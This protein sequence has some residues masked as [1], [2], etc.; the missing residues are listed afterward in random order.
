MRILDAHGTAA[1]LPY[2]KLVPAIALAASQKMSGQI[3]APERQVVNLDGARVLL[4]MPAVAH[5]IGINKFL[6]V[7]AENSRIGLPS[8]Q[9]EV[10]VFDSLTGQR[11]VMLDGPTLTGRRTAAVSML[12]ILTLARQKPT[13]VMLIGTGFQASIH[14]DALIEF[15]GVRHLLIA[16]RDTTN[17][18]AFCRALRARHAGSY[19]ITVEPV[20][21]HAIGQ[22]VP[23]PDVIIALTTSKIPVIPAGIGRDTLAIGVGAFK[24]DMAEFPPEL[25]HA[26]A[27][28]VD[29]LEGARHEA[30]DLI[31]AA[32][33]WSGVRE[34][35]QVLDHAAQPDEPVAVF[36]TVGQAAW[37]LAAARVAVELLNIEAK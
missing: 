1:A 2:A 14:A 12:G 29:C 15:L 37:D 11:I 16:G 31:Q 28:V 3:L 9:G 6:A 17:A 13:C 25:L 27:V 19:E 36:K 32:I 21:A 23:M 24:P 30:G 33:N 4:N 18:E 35:A 10:T 7:Y 26:R 34:L 5:D 8:I 22:S 20:A